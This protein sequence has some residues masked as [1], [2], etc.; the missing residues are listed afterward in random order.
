MNRM[1]CIILILFI[2]SPIPCIG[3]DVPHQIG[4]FIL[5]EKISAVADYVDMSTALPIRY[6]ENIKEVEIR[7]LKGFKSGLIAYGSCNSPERIVRI[8]MKYDDSSKAF[9]NTLRRKI[10][11]RFGAFDEYRGDPFQVV[12]SWKKSF[13]D[14]K[15]NRI[16]LTI[17]HNTSDVDEKLGNA[18]KLTMINLMEADCECHAKKT[19]EP[20]E[21]PMVIPGQQSWDLFLPR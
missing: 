10:E 19:S 17:Q 18:I 6:M 14:D 20:K 8:K 9:F 16:S 15:G 1:G 11:A 2:F 4:P 13:T 7:P 12:V 21:K 5:G 3:A